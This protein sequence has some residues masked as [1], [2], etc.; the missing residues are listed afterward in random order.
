MNQHLRTVI[1]APMATG[2][3]PTLGVCD[4]AFAIEQGSS[5]STNY[6]PSIANVS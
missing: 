1:V 2:V 4:A 3:M 6:A 5:P